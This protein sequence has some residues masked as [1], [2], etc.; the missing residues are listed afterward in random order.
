MLAGGI[1]PLVGAVL[2]RTFSD[3]WLPLACYLAVLTLLTI[4]T[5][6]LTPETRGRDLDVNVD[7]LAEARVAPPGDAVSAAAAARPG[8]AA[9]SRSAGRKPSRS[10]TCSR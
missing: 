2:L 3:S 1:A 6:F 4:V 7:A 8:S 5:T 9:A 10:R